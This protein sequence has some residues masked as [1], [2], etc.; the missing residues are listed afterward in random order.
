MK[1]ND[2]LKPDILQ[3]KPYSPNPKALTL[4]PKPPGQYGLCAS[5]TISCRSTA[6]N[7]AVNK[8]RLQANEDPQTPLY[9]IVP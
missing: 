3:P 4:N 9:G 7:P 2:F 1:P 6:P 8:S 5:L